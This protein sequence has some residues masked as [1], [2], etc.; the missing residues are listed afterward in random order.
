MIEKIK[1]LIA[2]TSVEDI[3]IGMILLHKANYFDR[4][5]VL[6]KF[7]IHENM[8]E[9][10]CAVFFKD[11]LLFIGREHLEYSSDIKQWEHCD[12]ESR[13]ECN[14]IKYEED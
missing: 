10:P 4:R 13:E 7:V 6:S 1:K 8:T 9:I 3:Q 2:S 12:E 11:Y 5:R 14:F